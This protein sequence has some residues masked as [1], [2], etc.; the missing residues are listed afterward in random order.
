MKFIVTLIRTMTVDADS[1]EDAICQAE[2]VWDYGGGG[3]TE[4]YEAELILD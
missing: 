3:D 2:Y 4:D 1:E